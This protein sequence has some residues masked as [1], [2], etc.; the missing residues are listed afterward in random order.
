MTWLTMSRAGLQVHTR[1]HLV[2]LRLAGDVELLP[3]PDEEVPRSTKRNG[4]VPI[5]STPSRRSPSPR[6]CERGWPGTGP[7]EADR[8]VVVHDLH[9]ATSSS[10]VPL[11]PAAEAEN[12]LERELQ[13][14]A[15]ISRRHA[16]R[17]VKTYVFGRGSTTGPG[18]ARLEVE[19]VRQALP[20]AVVVH[21]V[22]AS[23]WM[24]WPCAHGGL[25]EREAGQAQRL[26]GFRGSRSARAG[27]WSILRCDEVSSGVG[28]RA[29]TRVEG[30]EDP[31]S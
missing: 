18:G 30:L 2:H 28:S 9:P 12:A 11:A 26:R 24:S 29:E 8:T 31:G 6:S 22:T 15:F 25:G 19:A 4:P 17:R 7:T 13:S 20:G 3:A 16:T 14:A 1:R 27:T 5:G 21:A 10:S 23:C